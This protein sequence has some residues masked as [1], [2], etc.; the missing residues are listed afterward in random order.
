MLTSHFKQRSMLSTLGTNSIKQRSWF[1]NYRYFIDFSHL[2]IL[3]IR[4]Y[5]HFP[6]Q[7]FSSRPISTRSTQQKSSISQRHQKKKKPT[8]RTLLGMASERDEPAGTPGGK[9]VEVQVPRL[10]HQRREPVAV[11]HQRTAQLIR[12]WVRG[13]GRGRRR[14]IETPHLLYRLTFFFKFRQSVPCIA[15]NGSEK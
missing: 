7:Q 6:L 12:H 13:L 1:V 5:A 11:Y 4:N 2:I 9:R 15:F 10:G 14:G 3:K 8:A